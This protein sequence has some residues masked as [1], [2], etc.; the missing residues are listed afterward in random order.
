MGREGCSFFRGG[1]EKLFQT[2]KKI[3]PGNDCMAYMHPEPKV[4]NGNIDSAGRPC[5]NKQYFWPSYLS[6]S[7]SLILFVSISLACRSCISLTC[8]LSLSYPPSLPCTLS[9]L[10]FFLSLH[11]SL[12]L[13]TQAFPEL[14]VPAATQRLFMSRRKKSTGLYLCSFSCPKL[15]LKTNN[16]V[17][18]TSADLVLWRYI[19]YHLQYQAHSVRVTFL[20]STPCHLCYLHCH[21]ALQQPLKQTKW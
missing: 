3:L 12:S 15:C 10:F 11:S 13:F 20:P 2:C 7:L 6:L 4:E 9:S 19:L 16:H 14:C 5:Q 8:S 21:W 17:A 1:G 18:P